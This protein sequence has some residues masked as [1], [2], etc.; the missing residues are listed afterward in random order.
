MNNYALYKSY[1]MLAK[2]DNRDVLLALIY[3]DINKIDSD[4]LEVL[5]VIYKYVVDND[6]NSNNNNNSSN[7]DSITHEN[8]KD[9]NK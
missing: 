2:N 6:R 3:R 1:R 7:S 8:S 4:L 5:H 9:S